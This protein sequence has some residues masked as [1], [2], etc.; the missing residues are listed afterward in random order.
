M[1]YVPSEQI[2]KDSTPY[3]GLGEKSWV[4]KSGILA[5]I[6]ERYQPREKGVALDIGCGSGT[7]CDFLSHY[8]GAVHGVDIVDYR[9]E[10]LKVKSKFSAVD[11]NFEKLPYENNTFD[12]VSAFQVV[13]HLENPFLIMR[14][15]HR[16]LRPGGLF[17]FSVPN[18]YN[19]TFRMKYLLTANMPPWTRENNHLLFLT[20]EVF[21][22]TYLVYFDVLE[23]FYQKGAVP[24]W[25][26]LS[27]LFG[28][29]IKKHKKILP[30]SEAFSRR[31]GYVL[32]KK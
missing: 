17:I 28:K 31:I 20:K 7:V 11:L 10:Q 21:A 15:V 24:L 32:Q 18:P 8:F 3:E 6:L 30:A 9:N 4:V 14:E 29:R 23:R 5:K 19:L 16:V 26:R 2:R 1:R 12:V 22:K 13:E 27:I 25:G